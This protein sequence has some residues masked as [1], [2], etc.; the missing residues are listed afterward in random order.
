MRVKNFWAKQSQAASFGEDAGYPA[1]LFFFSHHACFPA[2]SVALVAVERGRVCWT[3]AQT[4]TDAAELNMS[5]FLT[6][7][8]I[9]ASMNIDYTNQIHYFQ[10]SI[11]SI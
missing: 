7:I 9:F 11:Y 6:E 4:L 10:Q 8:N 1:M 5:S 2:V 3:L